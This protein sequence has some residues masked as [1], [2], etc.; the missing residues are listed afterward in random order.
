M[1]HT[2]SVNPRPTLTLQQ[3]TKV[4]EQLYGVTI[5]EISTLPSYIDQNFLVVDKEGT[6]HVLKIMNSEESKRTT[7]LEVQTLAMSFLRQHEVP[8]QTAVPTTTGQLMSM[9][10]ID[11]G[12]GVQTYCVRLLTYIPGK[13]IQR[14]QVTMQDLYHV[15]KLAATVDKTL[16]QMVSPNL[17]V[18]LKYDTLWSLLNI[19]LLEG[20]L[21]VM[22]GDPLQEVVKAVIEQYK[23]HVQP[24]IISF[25][26]DPFTEG[27]YVELTCFYSSPEW[28]N[29]KLSLGII[30]GDLN[31]QNIIVIPIDTGHHEVSGILDFSLLVNG[32]YVF[33][34][35]ITIM[36][37]ML[38]NPSPLDVGGAVLAGWESIMQL[39][40]D[41]RDSLFLLV[42]GRLCQSLVYGRHNV[43][44]YPDNK[45]YI[46]TT[47]K[48]G[49]RL[50]V[51]LWEL[52]KKE[53][54]RKWFSD[55]RTFLV[56][57]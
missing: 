16:Q 53:V 46:L 2:T 1:D 8:A 21:S 6:K 33:E 57:K 45:S 42:L 36:Y 19:P 55:A 34:L 51:K 18:L 44:K 25:Q 13:T 22:D 26:K 29:Q 7:L 27:H 38:E 11:C 30:H 31:D 28:T 43:K 15:G 20:Y 23:S 12:H 49:S 24:K 40:D 52:G 54:E 32:C 5:T 39:N 3:A 9:E 10:E 41:E 37:L 17:D 56:S 35:A 4:I 50:L 14:S 48:S 47:A